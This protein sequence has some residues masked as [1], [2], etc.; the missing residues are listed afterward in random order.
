LDNT[1]GEWGFKQEYLCEFVDTITQVFAHDL[2]MKAVSHDVQ[3]FFPD[4][5]Q[6]PA[7][8]N[9]RIPV[10]FGGTF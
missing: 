8:S 10:L 3:P 2:F 5:L 9:P 6:Q 1:T 4:L 7:V